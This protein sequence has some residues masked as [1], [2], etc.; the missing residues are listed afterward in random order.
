MPFVLVVGLDRVTK[1]VIRATLWDP[2][3]QRI[4]VPSWLE[5]TPVENR[6]IAFGMLQTVGPLLA[7][8]AV[9]VLG[10]IALRNWRQVLGAPF[11]VRV[12][13]GLIAGG[14]IGN[15]IDRAQFG[16]VTDFIRVPRIEL[17]QVFN[18]SDAS[19]VVGTALLAI[20]T[21]W[22][23]ARRPRSGPT[24]TPKVEPTSAQQL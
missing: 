1:W 7:I 9:V 24:A 19:I 11:L 10:A 20:A 6:G 15:V 14:A 23:D 2:P 5:L 17:F 3:R 12:A 4:I 18:V 8:V 13:L 22:A 16:Y 21:L